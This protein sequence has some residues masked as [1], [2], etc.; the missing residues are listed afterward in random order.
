MAR[1]SR[2]TISK[3]DI[4]AVF[5]QSSQRVYSEKELARLLSQHRE[6]WRLTDRTTVGPFI[7]FLEQQEKLVAHEF[8]SKNYDRKVKRYS[9]GQVSPYQLAL[10]IQSNG[11]LSHSTAVALHGLTDIIPKTFYLNVE[12]SPKPPPKGGLS[13]RG[14]DLAF[15]RRQRQSAMTY[16]YEDWSVTILNGKNTRNLGVETVF[17]L[18]QETL[19]TTNIERTLIDIVV[20]PNYSG[21]I[22]QILESYKRAKDRVSTNRLAAT[23]KQ[24]DYV[25]PYHQAIGFL[26]DMAG[27]GSKSR[28]MERMGLNH[29]FYLSHGIEEPEYS[30]KWRLFFPRGLDTSS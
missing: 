12:Q 10:S 13:Q 2:L 26:M 1:P 23:L 9:W 17:G 21:G 30:K 15:S 25:Y 7:K 24:L 28:L 14:I 6:F 3:K 11:Y 4:F 8:H 16:D 20:R 5:E 29:D 22:F 27:Y 19:L 18:E